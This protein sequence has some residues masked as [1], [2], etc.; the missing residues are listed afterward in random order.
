MCRLEVGGELKDGRQ[1]SRRDRLALF[2][3]FALMRFS[4]LFLLSFFI[5]FIFSFL[6]SFF[7]LH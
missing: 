1:R 4:F 3:S 7:L 6:F 5:S 2:F